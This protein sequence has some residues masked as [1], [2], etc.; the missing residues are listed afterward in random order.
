MKIKTSEFIIERFIVFSSH[1]ESVQLKDGYKSLPELS[2]DIDFDLFESKRPIEDYR[3]V[4]KLNA[5]LS[6]EIP[7]YSFSIVT[8]VIFKFKKKNLNEDTKKEYLINSGLP[9]MIN[10]TRLYLSNLTFYG[11]YGQYLL[12]LI[13]IKDLIRKK[14]KK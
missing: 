6:K 11:S 14:N 10:S 13:D 9:L 5:N 7:G 4:L 3:I 8:Q 2:L 12:P 1:I